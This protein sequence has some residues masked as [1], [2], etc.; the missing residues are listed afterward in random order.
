MFWIN[1]KGVGGECELEKTNV[2]FSGCYR[3]VKPSELFGQFI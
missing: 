3:R 1:Y 2:K